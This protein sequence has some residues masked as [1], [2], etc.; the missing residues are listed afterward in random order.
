M[1]R[2][3][4][5]LSGAA[6]LSAPLFAQEPADTTALSM[7]K[8]LE[9]N[10][11]MV[12]AKRQVLKQEPDRIVY[13]VKNDPYAAGLG[14]MEL[15]DRIPRVSVIND[16]VSVAGKNSV[17]YIVDGHLLDMTDE[18][19]T[20]KLKSIQADGVEKIELLTTPPAKY[21]AAD[22]AAY[23]SITTRNESHGT[24]GNL[25]GRGGVSEDF[26]YSLGGSVC[27][28]TRKTELSADIGWNDT[29]GRNDIFKRYDFEDYT[30]I[31]D[32]TTSFI[33]R[34]LSANA[35]FKYKF[36]PRL[37]IGAIAN[38]NSN[39]MLTDVEDITV[40]GAEFMRSTSYTPFYPDDALTLTGFADWDIDSKGKM[41]S[42]TY[43]FFDKESNSF[44]DVTTR[45]SDSE[46]S[47]LTKQG[48]NIY[49]IHSVK[50]DVVL[51]FPTFRIEA[52][53]AYTAISNNTDL[54]IKNEVGDEFVDDSSQSN[55]FLYD[56]KTS[57]VYLSGERNFGN[58]VYVKLALRYEHTEV[59]GTQKAY[60]MSNERSSDYFF[61]TVNISHNF[62]GAG[63][64]SA[65]YSI[66]I[67]RP[68][69]GD[70][71]PFRY[72]N[73]VREYF[74]GNPNLESVIVQNM[75]INYNYKGVYAVVYGS[76]SKNAVGYITRF[77]S[78]GMQSTT[79][80]NCLNTYKTGVYASYNRS[81]TDWWNVNLGGEIFYSGSRSDND[82]FRE[83]HN[84]GCSGKAEINTSWMLN[85][86]KSL[87]FNL[88]ATHFF[89]Y[90]DRM[91]YYRHRTV[92][93]CELRYM[94]FENHLVISASLNDPFRWSV[95]R[96]TACYRD[97]N[98]YSKI[99]IHDHS[100]ALRAVWSFGGKKVNNVYRDTKERESPRAN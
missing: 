63:R 30:H 98:L 37:S 94:L 48:D 85:K 80:E 60:D 65:D 68:G 77:D 5:L 87:I 54:T 58:L 88:R 9:L 76:W 61:P 74:T 97:Y 20:L 81:L 12:V 16:L 44:S 89:P 53:G 4:M 51:P 24:R 27:H 32:R 10:E 91:T 14:G 67:S 6:A 83:S 73:T 92:I 52:G 31:S 43:N 8:E 34:T 78:D 100:V 18:A 36:D 69:F 45:W 56:E 33:W 82:D 19:I 59:K 62:P 99:N 70:L 86:T 1:N 71:N 15:L 29:K 7:G 13:L 46:K 55:E 28:T 21:A 75:G 93:G 42:L 49:R 57:A 11:V 64:L 3:I 40:A 84:S 23:I 72:Y 90:H 79:P 41:L 47:R 26:R 95:T 25:W 17:R 2:L 22:N 39:R 66:G 38:F 50:L 35:L 96:S